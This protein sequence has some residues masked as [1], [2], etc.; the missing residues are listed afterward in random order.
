[1]VDIDTSSML[2]YDDLKIIVGKILKVLFA[3]KGMWTGYAM[4]IR[5]Q[6]LMPCDL[7]TY[8]FDVGPCAREVS[9]LVTRML[10]CQDVGANELATA[11]VAGWE[12]CWEQG[13]IRFKNGLLVAGSDFI[14]R[15]D[16]RD[17]EIEI[18]SRSPV[19]LDGDIDPSDFRT[20]TLRQLDELAIAVVRTN[21]RIYANFAHLPVWRRRAVVASAEGYEVQALWYVLLERLLADDYVGNSVRVL[22]PIQ[23]SRM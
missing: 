20:Y 17:L 14:W 19:S 21:W 22:I 7:A 9:L 1:L 15:R 2:R 12:L 5:D 16:I 10:L 23:G 8:G 3:F 4:C 18:L 13:L 6:H 11:Q